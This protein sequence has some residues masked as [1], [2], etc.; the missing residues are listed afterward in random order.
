MDDNKPFSL[1]EL[2]EKLYTSKPTKNLFH[3]TSLDGIVGIHK[4]EA[5]WATSVQYFNDASELRHAT[6]LFQRRI[7]H[8]LG[9]NLGS[10]EVLTRLRDWLKSPLYVK[11]ASLYAVSFTEKR[12]SL[13]QWRGYTPLG[14]GACVE[15][16]SQDVVS[17][18]AAQG[19]EMVK[20]I[21]DFGEK[22]KLVEEALS[23][24]LYDVNQI[25]PSGATET[26]I[27]YS[28]FEKLKPDLLR[29]AVAFKDE[30]FK[31]EDE[32]RAVLRRNETAITPIIKYRVGKST[33]IPYVHYSLV[34]PITNKFSVWNIWIGPTPNPEL[35]E[36]AL[37]SLFKGK[38]RCG[39]YPVVHSRAPYRE[40]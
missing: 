26:H 4:D 2:A 23:A 15:F 5:I 39:R 27:F 7:D 40:T 37:K 13:S 6:D 38:I 1:A 10:K 20:C 17:Y 8:L 32:W 28:A 14:R 16:D 21:Y 35:S 24:F 30:A 36:A 18:C 25:L 29:I 31:D 34:D 11:N 22:T 9:N 3:Y 12:D 33:L 19:Y